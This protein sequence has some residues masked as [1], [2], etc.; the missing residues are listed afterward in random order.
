MK[1]LNLLLIVSIVAFIAITSSSCRKGRNLPVNVPVFIDTT[2]IQAHASEIYVEEYG[3]ELEYITERMRE[4]LVQA[5]YQDLQYYLKKNNCVKGDEN[6]DYSVRVNRI[7]LIETI[8]TKSYVDSCATNSSG[9]LT[10]DNVYLSELSY[11]SDIQVFKKGGILLG[12]YNEL[13][14]KKEKT[15]GKNR[16]NEPRVRGILLGAAG[17]RKRG[18]KSQRAN[19]TKAIHFDWKHGEN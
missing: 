11:S 19:I 10:Y 1:M 15:C 5:F 6:S 8:S 7:S 16:C 4:D 9:Y 3:I 12:V 14:S 17:M 13:I 2:G 18:T